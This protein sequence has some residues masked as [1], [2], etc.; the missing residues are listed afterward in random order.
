MLLFFYS[1]RIYSLN[2][3]IL[4][5]LCFSYA[6]VRAMVVQSL[7]RLWYRSFERF[8]ENLMAIESKDTPVSF[9]YR[10]LFRIYFSLYL[11][12]CHIHF[13]SFIISDVLWLISTLCYIKF[14]QNYFWIWESFISHVA[15]NS[16]KHMWVQDRDLRVFLPCL[17]TPGTYDP[18]CPFEDFFKCNLKI[19]HD[20][21]IFFKMAFKRF[22][23]H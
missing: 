3:L 19:Y 8:L 11:F 16:G 15:S 22:S 5:F 4:W 23:L 6:N 12:V 2:S 13:H 1:R 20:L 18:L 14:G 7:A 9:P 10:L 21:L 17:S